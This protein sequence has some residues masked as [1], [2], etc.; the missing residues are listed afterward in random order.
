[1]L[2][3]YYTYKNTITYIDVLPKFV[4]AYNDRVHSATVM[5]PSRVIDSDVLAIWKRMEAR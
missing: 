4:K 1:M 5:A 3:K 2:Y